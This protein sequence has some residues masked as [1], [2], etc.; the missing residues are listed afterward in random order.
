V[1]HLWT[2]G[3]PRTQCRV[4]RFELDESLQWILTSRKQANLRLSIQNALMFPIQSTQFHSL[5]HNNR[6]Q[7]PVSHAQDGLSR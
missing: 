4:R 6:Q 7:L 3:V 5:F 2:R 1:P